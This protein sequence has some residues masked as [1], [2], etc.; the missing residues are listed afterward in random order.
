M[1]N[2]QT[3]IKIETV[4]S[5]FFVI[6]FLAGCSEEKKEHEITVAEVG[7][8]KLTQ[9][10]LDNQ[11]GS[12]KKNI[13]YRD[14]IIRDWIETQVL[15]QVAE[16]NNLLNS[17]NYDQIIKVTQKEI[18]A[19]IAIEQFLK[20]H[21]IEFSESELRRFFNENKEDF[22][23]AHNTYILNFI[24][25]SDEGSAI[26]FRNKAISEGW[27]AAFTSFKADTTMIENQENKI[28]NLSDIQSKII[29]RVLQ[30]LYN[31]E[32]SLV[33]NT[34]LNNF[35]VVQQID[36]IGKNDVPKFKFVRENVK[37]NLIRLKQKEK[38]RSYVDSLVNTMNVKI[39]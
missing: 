11:L 31:T 18:A 13:R 8:A 36:Q 32:I 6:I 28:F 39:Y 3:H 35:V 26:R 21:P 10:E 24:S 38:V 27:S 20:S 29:H 14:E 17:E 7:P 22:K 5:L 34:E 1:R 9:S 19:S 4:I 16:N 33:I 2:W 37:N 30:K 12:I 23:F 15:S 25:F